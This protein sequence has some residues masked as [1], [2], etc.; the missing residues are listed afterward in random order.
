[1]AVGS[2][3]TVFTLASHILQPVFP[4]RFFHHYHAQR[5]RE[6]EESHPYHTAEA[7]DIGQAEG[8]YTW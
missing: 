1:M 3:A 6:K 4:P 8:F 5:N 7:G 2:C